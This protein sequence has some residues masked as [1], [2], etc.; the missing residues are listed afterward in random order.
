M[1]SAAVLITLFSGLGTWFAIVQAQ[2]Y[3]E[4]N[5]RL[6]AERRQLQEDLQEERDRV[7]RRDAELEDLDAALDARD[8]EMKELQ[9]ALAEETRAR[10]EAQ[11]FNDD[12]ITG[13]I[14]CC[15]FVAL[16]LMV[17][18]FTVGNSPLLAKCPHPARYPLL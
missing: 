7:G 15:V 17:W 13:G 14:C 1:E 18:A 9:E 4:E 6:T 8:E 5:R 3:M 10:K 16:A 2:S 12:A 11:R